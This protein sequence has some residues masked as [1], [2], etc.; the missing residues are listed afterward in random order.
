MLVQQPL[1]LRCQILLCIQLRM[2]AS[3]ASFGLSRG[4]VLSLREVNRRSPSMG[5]AK[6][7]ASEGNSKEASM[8]KRS[9]SDA[10]IALAK[11]LY[12]RAKAQNMLKSVGLYAIALSNG[13]KA[14]RGRVATWR[15]Y[16]CRKELPQESSG[17][18]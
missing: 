2:A 3:A 11:R 7:A 8:T 1:H 17:Q 6:C 12:N 14:S 9:D 13:F 5:L 18:L 10:V 15:D 16:P 4:P